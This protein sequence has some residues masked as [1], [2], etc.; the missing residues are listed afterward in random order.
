MSMSKEKSQIL[1]IVCKDGWEL[2]N[3]E[4]QWKSDKEVVLA[5]VGNLGHALE[6]ADVRLKKDK[7][8]VLAAIM[9]PK[10]GE[11]IMH[12]DAKLK[13]DKELVLAA[14]K[15]CNGYGEALMY[16]DSKLKKDKE[17]VLAAIM[18]HCEAIEHADKTLK[19]DREFM[20]EA[21]KIDDSLL[22]KNWVSAI[23]SD[24]KL[25]GPIELTIR[26]TGV[27]VVAGYIDK[28]TA[29]QINEEMD[30]DEVKEIVGD[31]DV[32]EDLVHEFYPLT[33]PEFSEDNEIFP[34]LKMV[35]VGTE[36]I[37]IKGE[38]YMMVT[39]STEDGILGKITVDSEAEE[40]KYYTKTY[41]IADHDLDVV[42]GF[43]YKD[44][45]L[46]LDTS[47]FSTTGKSIDIAIYNRENG[48]KIW[49]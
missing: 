10:N 40:I 9:S 26:G 42:T 31:W 11:A 18:S 34:E 12:A 43:N 2:Q 39:V 38:G 32:I 13:K 21:V 48:K 47:D 15:N 29:E 22:A 35:N 46:E 6:F 23:V 37:P 1:E 4:D 17:V 41:K 24:H 49:S 5:A 28:E 7:E 16:V 45:D 33:P 20:L 3:L 8:V 27:E 25:Q 19:T 44:E 30:W 14:V 36:K